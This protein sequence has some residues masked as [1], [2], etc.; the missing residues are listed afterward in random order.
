MWPAP[1][2]F[3][4]CRVS[5]PERRL[6]AARAARVLLAC[7]LAAAGACPATV[8]GADFPASLNDEGRSARAASGPVSLAALRL[9]AG[10]RHELLGER[11]WLHGMPAQVLVFDA[12]HSA[13]ELIRFLSGR[14]PALADLNV[15]PGQAILSGQVGHEQWVVQMEGLGP[16][17]TVGSI[18]TIRLDAAAGPPEPSWL[19]AG[20]RLRLDIGVLDQ[21]VKVTERIWQYDS[22]PER[23]APRLEAALKQDGWEASPAADG[24]SQWWTRGKARLRISLMPLD[25][26]SGLLASGWAQ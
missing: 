10:T 24:G 18:S 26:G 2:F 7:M 11:V 13:P 19:P 3:I 22:P 21:G 20:A 25:A 5:V 15:L 17:R 16:R 23:V 1:L 12:P 14:Q 8:S 9:P 4:G 6:A